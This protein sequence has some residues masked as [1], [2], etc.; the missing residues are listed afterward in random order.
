[1]NLDTNTFYAFF[2]IFVRCSG[3]C[4]AAPVF[5]AMNIPVRIRISLA[6]ALAFT[7][8]AILQPKVGQPPKDMIEFALAVGNEALSG[9]LIGGFFGL[10]L[11]AALMAGAFI[12]LQLGLGLSQALNPVAG[13]PVSVIGQFKYMLCLV[14]FLCA[15]AHHLMLSSLVQ[16]YSSMPTLSASLMP[17][18]QEGILDLIGRLS[19]LALQMAM[20]VVAVSFIVD[21]GLALINKAVPQMQSFFVGMPVKIGLGMLVLTLALPAM[22]IGVRSGVE[23][24]MEALPFASQSDGTAELPLRTPVQGA[25]AP[26]SAPTP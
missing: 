24:A 2:L 22:T 10:V 7:L 25:S 9:I 18:L 14:I 6:G 4:L 11:Q 5:G 13:V 26:S 21:A 1:M 16:S 12:D 8:L 23:H 19:L 20:P 15:D 3:L 17:A